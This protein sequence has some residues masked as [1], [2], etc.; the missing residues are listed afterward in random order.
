MLAEQTEDLPVV[1]TVWLAKQCGPFTCG[2]DQES[3][4]G[5]AAGHGQPGIA[6]GVFIGWAQ[7]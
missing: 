5:V 3:L 1:D 2:C 7:W 4:H 6:V